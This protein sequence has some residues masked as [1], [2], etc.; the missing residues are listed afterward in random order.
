MGLAGLGHWCPGQHHGME[1]GLGGRAPPGLHCPAQRM[2]TLSPAPPPLLSSAGGPHG[3]SC[4]HHGE[5]GTPLPRAAVGPRSRHHRRTS[6]PHR[7]GSGSL[8]GLLRLPQRACSRFE[9]RKI[10]APIFFFFLLFLKADAQ[11]N[12]A[13]VPTPSQACSSQLTL[14]CGKCLRRLTLHHVV[15]VLAQKRVRCPQGWLGLRDILRLSRG[16]W[17]GGAPKWLTC[18]THGSRDSIHSPCYH[19]SWPRA[20]WAQL[21][22]SGVHLC[23]SVCVRMRLCVCAC[24]CVC[25]RASVCVCVCVHASVCIC[26]C[27]RLCVRLCVCV[28][29]CVRVSVCVS[30]RACVCVCICACICVCASVCIC[31]CMRAS[32]CVSVRVCVCV[33]VCICVC[34]CVCACV[35]VCVCVCVSVCVSVCACVRL[36]VY[37]CV[38]LCVCASVCICVCMCVCARVCV[39][40]CAC[41]CVCVRLCVRSSVCVSVCACVCVC[42]FTHT[43]GA[44]EA[45]TADWTG[46]PAGSLVRGWDLLTG[47]RA[48]LGPPHCRT[49][50]FQVRRQRDAV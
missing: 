40:I 14:F 10:P 20:H 16:R 18:R 35:C 38:H 30:V 41:V 15:Q 44:G 49:R 5:D 27:V 21:C 25:A 29:L 46:A 13:E 6:Q 34:M 4:D 23:V 19:L 7:P 8:W 36:C 9:I 28:H 42:V 17:G 11:T 12:V 33:S 31:V 48:Q 43:C 24:V 47:G 22:S 37:L 45:G 1:G 50:G 2:G 3:G 32:V 26:V 39:C